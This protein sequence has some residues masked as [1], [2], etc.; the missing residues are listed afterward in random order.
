[1][2]VFVIKFGPEK[3]KAWYNIKIHGIGITRTA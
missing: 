2:E 3:P 1:M